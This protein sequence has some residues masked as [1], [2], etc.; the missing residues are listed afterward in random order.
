VDE[1]KEAGI[2]SMLDEIADAHCRKFKPKGFDFNISLFSDGSQQTLRVNWQAVI[3]KLHQVFFFFRDLHVSQ[4][5]TLLSIAARTPAYDLVK[6]M[7]RSRSP[8]LASAAERREEIV[9]SGA[10]RARFSVPTEEK[11]GAP[12]RRNPR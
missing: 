2:R 3:L 11:E 10:R 6:R 7:G 5:L 9:A 4:L 8:S 12:V 1:V